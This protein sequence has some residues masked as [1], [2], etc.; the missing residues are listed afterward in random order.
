[1]SLLGRNWL[2]ELKLNWQEIVKIDGV[3]K[4]LPIGLE[5]LLTQYSEIFKPG[6]GHCRELKAK[7]YLKDGV[8]PKFNCPRPTA[9]AMKSVIEEELDHRE[10]LSC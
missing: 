8:I 4:H 3:T 2:Q 10:K 7:L 9:V 1:M 6:L 5:E